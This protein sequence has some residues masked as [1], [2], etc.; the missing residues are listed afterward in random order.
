ML[1]S[2]SL[3]SVAA[4]AAVFIRARPCSLRAFPR[5]LFKYDLVVLAL[6]PAT[7]LPEAVFGAFAF[8]LMLEPFTPRF[9][10]A[11]AELLV[12]CGCELV[13]LVPELFALDGRW[14]RAL[15]Y[16]CTLHDRCSMLRWGSWVAM[17]T[18]HK[19]AYSEN[20]RWH[21]NII[22]GNGFAHFKS[23]KCTD[24]MKYDLDIQHPTIHSCD[25]NTECL[26]PK[27][28]GRVYLVML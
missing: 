18:S 28:G 9:R 13:V 20:I 7:L 4:R 16:A 14:S 15:L 21:W 24:S 23:E 26:N 8:G 11:A 17:E 1:L 12:L 2:A 22:R 27:V 5:R 6:E 25:N 3:F 10:V 19:E